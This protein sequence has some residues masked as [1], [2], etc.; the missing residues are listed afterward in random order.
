MKKILVTGGCGFVGSSLAISFKNRYP[1]LDVLCLDNLKR[2]GSELNIPRLKK[3]GIEFVHGDVRNREDIDATG[4]VDVV[5]DC[6]AEPSVLAGYGTSPEY[7]INTNLMGTINCLEHA[8]RCGSAF[9]FLSTSRVYPHATINRLNYSESA[10]RYMLQDNQDIIGASSKGFTEAFP[11]AGARSLY[12]ASKLA[13]E[14]MIQEYCDMYALNAVINRCGTITGPWQFGKADQGVIVLWVARH[15]WKQQLSY[16]GFGGKGKQVR[17]L[18][19][20]QDI[21]E[22]LD[23]QIRDVSKHNGQ[24]YNVGGGDLSVSLRELTTLCEDVTGNK[25]NIAE[26]DENRPADIRVYTTDLGKVSAATGWK[27]KSTPQ[28]IVSDIYEWI[29]TNHNILEGVL[30]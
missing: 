15:F 28:A 21:F 29:K 2:R 7:L 11:L 3:H 4:C 12:G 1:G 16:I 10:S 5:L 23:I 27:P 9:I 8:R 19:H 30:K 24:I 18:L 20:V 22:L 13:S 25:I 26:I 6:S 14:L 17:D